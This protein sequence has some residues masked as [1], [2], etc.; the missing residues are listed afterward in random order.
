MRR[1]ARREIRPV[2]HTLDDAGDKCGAVELAHLAGHADVLVDE[3]LVVNNHVLLGR[4]GVGR[5]L[6]AVGLAGEE[7]LP[8]VLLDEVEEGDDGR[9]AL[10]GAGGL[11]V[12]EEVEEFQADGVALKVEAG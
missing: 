4:L 2:A 10:L 11:A 12:E 6:E 3:G 7:V 1:H 5:L 9:G 8:D